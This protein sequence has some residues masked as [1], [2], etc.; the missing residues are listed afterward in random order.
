MLEKI[1]RFITDFSYVL[2]FEY[3]RF[4]H[5]IGH[6]VNF[7]THKKSNKNKKRIENSKDKWLIFENTHEPIISQ[8]DFDLVQETRKNKRKIQ[9]CGEVNPFSGMVYCADRGAK[10]YFCCSRSM[11]DEQEHMK[12]STYASD[13]DECSAHF[14]RTVV[15]RKLVLGELNKLLETFHANEGLK[16]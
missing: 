9:K 14:I 2:N 16:H 5:D 6:T 11:T 8:H 15:L 10:M 13:S 1:G 7:K 4:S 3:R 12:C